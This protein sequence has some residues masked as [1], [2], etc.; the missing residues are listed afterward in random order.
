MTREDNAPTRVG[1]SIHEKCKQLSARSEPKV[2]VFINDD[3]GMDFLDFEDAFNGFLLYG[4][5][6]VGYHKNIAARKVAEGRIRDEKWTIDMYVWINRY[7]G[8]HSFR[9]DGTPLAPHEEVG[10]FL[11]FA[12]DAGYA[13]ARKFFGI[14]EVPKP[15]PDAATLNVGTLNEMLLREALGL[16]IGRR[17]P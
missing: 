13:L 17:M 6:T 12:S 16:P 2:L 8:R 7:D 11:R 4:N 10:P 3:H 9:A 14:P 1:N 5:E 15:E